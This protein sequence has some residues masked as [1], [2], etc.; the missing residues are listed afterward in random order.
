M[1]PCSQSQIEQDHFLWIWATTQVGNALALSVV[2][3]WGPVR[4]AV[5]G[6][7]VARPPRMTMVPGRAVD[8]TLLVG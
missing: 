8:S 2:V 7:L 1:N 5:T 6:T 3:R 4:T